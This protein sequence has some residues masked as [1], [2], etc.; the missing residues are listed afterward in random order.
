M[1]VMV[2]VA[3]EHPKNSL[4]LFC[5][6]FPIFQAK[7]LAIKFAIEPRVISTKTLG[8]GLMKLDKKQPIVTPITTGHPKIID[9]GMI[10]SATRT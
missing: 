5:F 7:M 2:T 10:A 8:I 3:I 6:K 4:I 9:S 1:K